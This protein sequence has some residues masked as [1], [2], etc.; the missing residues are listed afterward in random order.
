MT[1]YS[2][3]GESWGLGW[4]K[5]ATADQRARRQAFGIYSTIADRAISG[6]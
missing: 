6:K 5:A 3:C 1:I 2:D 4:N